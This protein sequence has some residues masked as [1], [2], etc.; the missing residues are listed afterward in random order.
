M[1]QDVT[2]DYYVFNVNTGVFHDRNVIWRGRVEVADVPMAII[3]VRVL[4][5]KYPVTFRVYEG[6]NLASVLEVP[7]TSD[8]IRKLPVMRRGREWSFE[9]E[10]ESNIISVEAGTSGRVR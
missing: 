2:Y 10:G 4:A 5:D 6:D 3:T 1:M 9:V 7:L 8:K